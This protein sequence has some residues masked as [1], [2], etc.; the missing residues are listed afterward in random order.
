[1]ADSTKATIDPQTRRLTLINVY[2]VEPDKQA[3]LV[4]AL[5]QATESTI[6]HQ[7]GFISVCLHSS[8]DGA[9]V[10]NYAQ[11]ESK[12]DFEGFMKKP[13]TQEQLK[14]FAGL[15]KSVA[16]SLYSVN[17]VIAG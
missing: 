12:E 14:Q 3:A 16:P 7:P 10:V 8:I 13:E 9:K 17:S 4:E 6:R 15:A 5:T 1:M 2:E 11:W